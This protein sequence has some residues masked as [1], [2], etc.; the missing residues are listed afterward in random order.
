MERHAFT[1]WWTDPAGG[2]E[3]TTSTHFSEDTTVYARWSD[4]PVEHIDISRGSIT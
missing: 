3:I 1:G 2:R 4:I